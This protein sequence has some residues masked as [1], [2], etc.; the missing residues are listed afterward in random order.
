MIAIDLATSTSSARTSGLLL[1]DLT[2]G[3]LSLPFA[4]LEATSMS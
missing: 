2:T 3:G 1:L 4:L